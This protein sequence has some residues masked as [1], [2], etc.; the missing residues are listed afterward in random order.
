[1]AIRRLRNRE[2]HD[3]YRFPGFV[4][5][6]TVRSVFGDPH[7][8][9]LTL[10]RR[11]KNSL[12]HLRPAPPHLVRPLAPSGSRHPCGDLRIYLEFDLRR[13]ACRHCGGVKRER[14]D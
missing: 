9:V 2:L 4:P 5:A 6:R 13:V 11:A 3:A 14:L 8:R 10:T 1:M 12:R 7:A